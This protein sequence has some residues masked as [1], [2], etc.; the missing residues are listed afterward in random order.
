MQRRTFIHLLA[1]STL[2]AWF[3]RMTFA[4]P[5]RRLE[6]RHDV[7]VCVFLR[8]GVDGVS[9]VV[10]FGD[11]DLYRSRPTLAI[12]PPGSAGS[13]A[14]DLDGFFGLHPSL[15]PLHGIFQDGSLAIVHAVG[16]PD[17]TRSH[18]DAMDFME[19][20]TPGQKVLKSGWIARHLASHHTG[21]PSPFRAVSLGPSIPASMR[22]PI[23]ATALRSIADFH[24][25][26]DPTEAA[27]FQQVMHSLYAGAGLLGAQ[28]DRTFGA[29]EQL[30]QA[31]PL[32]YQPRHGASYPATDFGLALRQTAQMLRA[33]VGLEVACLD[34]G[35]WDTHEGQGASAGRLADLLTGLAAGLEAFHTDLQDEMGRVTLVVMTEFGRRLAENASEGTDHGRATVMFAMGAGVEG[36]RVHGSWPGLAPENLE[37]PGDLAVTTDFR[38]VLSELLVQRLGNSRLG[39]VFPGFA[40][41]PFLGVFRD[42]HERMTVAR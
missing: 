13:S 28:A 9:A 14:R 29:I 38:T 31:N 37:P 18:F 3:P 24:L 17:D 32:Q 4:T 5:D 8:G 7:L 39:D 40:P 33:E 6:S 41:P 36:G 42:R 10:P 35:G 19:R 2:P 34:I 27:S 15:A 22:G 11:D 25:K 12:A 16:S 23:S 21:N 30:A 1:G 26:G 20:G